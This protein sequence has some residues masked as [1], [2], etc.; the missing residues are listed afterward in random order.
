M[1][2]ITPK[3]MNTKR[4]LFWA[5]L[6]PLIVVALDQWS[7]H[8]ALKFFATKFGSPMNVCAVNPQP[9]LRWEVTQGFDLAMVCNQGV[10]WGLL[11]GESD[12]KRWGL[13]IFALLMTAGMLYFLYKTKDWL[14][15]LALSLIIGG[16][17]GNV[18][19]RIRFGS[20]VDFLDFG[21]IG[22]HWVFNVADAAISVGVGVLLLASFLVK[23]EEKPNTG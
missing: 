22:F 20:V 10:S 8:W 1:P 7:K 2:K 14:T 19:D 16:S 17:I 5:G 11:G 23:D 18:I 15:A 12:I 9:G 6:L 4:Y 3:P 21:D 13:S